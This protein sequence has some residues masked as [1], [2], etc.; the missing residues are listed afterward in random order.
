MWHVATIAMSHI[1]MILGEQPAVVS[2]RLN[3][4]ASHADLSVG[5][6]GELLKRF[7][8]APFVRPPDSLVFADGSE[9][10][11]SIIGDDGMRAE[12]MRLA[13]SEHVTVVQVS[14]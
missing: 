11:R 4:G 2:E 12:L 5:E 10:L 9:A 3:H 8:G 1:S 13:P 7:S 14:E 6:F